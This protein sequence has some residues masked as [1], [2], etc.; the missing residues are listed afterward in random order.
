MLPGIQIVYQG[1]LFISSL[2]A[3]TQ[4]LQLL[5]SKDFTVLKE[6]R[7]LKAEIAIHAEETKSMLDLDVFYKDLD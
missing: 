5:D 2:Q 4:R 3:Q 6:K 1:S 7:I